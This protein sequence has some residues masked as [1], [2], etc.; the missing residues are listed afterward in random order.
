M[1]D[2]ELAEKEA[3]FAEQDLLDISDDETSFPDKG[4]LDAERALADSAKVIR[5]PAPPSLIRQKSSFLGPTPRE[6]QAEFESHS[7]KQRA[8]SRSEAHGITRAATA[9]DAEV[10]SS[11]SIAKPKGKPTTSS[12]TKTG[13]DK[14][15]H[16]VS[17]PDL[18]S[19]IQNQN[20]VPFYKQVGEIPRALT[21]AKKAKPTEIKLE[22][23][24]KQLLKGKIIYFFP[25]D[26]TSQARRMRIHK[27]I[28][29]GAAWVKKWQSDITHI[30]TDDDKHTV[31]T[32][33]QVLRHLNRVSLPRNVVLV[34]FDPYVPQCI[35]LATLLEPSARRFQVKGAPLRAQP[36]T[37]VEPSSSPSSQTSLQVKLSRRQLAAHDSQKTES[38]TV[39]DS[40]LPVPSSDTPSSP[41]DGPVED[42]FA[43]PSSD[44]PGE[45]A[46]SPN[47]YSY[48][49]SEAIQQAK[50]VSHLPLDE[51]SDSSPS[52]PSSS[53]G[54]EDDS[55]TDVESPKPSPKQAKE[56]ALKATAEDPRTFNQN[57]FQ[58]MQPNSNK[59]SQNPNARTIETLQEMAKYYDQMQD[60]WRTLA[61][62]RGISTLLKQKQ[63]IT[64]KE[65]A[66]ALPYIGSRLAEKIEEIVLTN[67]LRRLDN[68]R[69]DPND[70][71]LQLFLGIYGVGVSQAN[72]WIQAGHRSLDDLLANA[73]LTDTQRIGIEHYSDFAA[74]IPRAEVEAHGKLV[75]IALQNL[76]PGCEVTL[77]GSYRRGANDSGDIDLIITKK[78]ASI[79]A[80]RTIIFNTLVPQLFS[81]DFLKVELATSHRS[82][83]GTKWLGASCLPNSNNWRRLDLLLV[84]EAE[85][86]AALIYFTGNDV[87]NR[88]M[89][90]LAS[91]KGMRLNR[92]GLYRG[93]IRGKDRERLTEETLVEGRSEKR[94]FEILGVSWREPTERIC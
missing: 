42:S 64:T 77:M 35:E 94:I 2:K 18:N 49:L 10:S 56:S 24:R 80:L 4:L 27:V 22:P 41:L 11:F 81:A 66:A 45:P 74:R 36:N 73:K 30:M 53:A 91:K 55:G 62:R 68:M 29:L 15:K 50:A 6:R 60:Q 58:C 8:A 51:V 87:F 54:N 52:R 86:G 43:L 37:V 5:P 26:D 47:A 12:S 14:S 92:R 7:S 44:P 72:K 16:S 34:K 63:K 88:S 23:E 65:G 84:P 20:Q 19:P 21:N 1:L 67:K 76:D 57:N 59:S 78:G 46:N 89:R 33:S 39:K 90:L 61:Y 70:Q 93:V 83:D 17:L 82:N 25:N 48:A 3:Y 28:Q 75:R 85:M 79:S 32:Y 71:I 40:F 69:D 31:Y 13:S 38:T 9:P